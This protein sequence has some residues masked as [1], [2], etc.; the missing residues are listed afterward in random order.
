MSSV[1]QLFGVM[2]AIFL[3]IT[4]IVFVNQYFS[5]KRSTNAQII[6]LQREMEANSTDDLEKEV[7]Q[8]KERIIVLESIVTDRGFELERNI[9][10]L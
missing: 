9:S 5:Y 4:M 10:N 8:L 1:L 2:M 6:K 3:P 7:A